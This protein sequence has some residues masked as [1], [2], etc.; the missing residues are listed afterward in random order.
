MDGRRHPSTGLS[1][2]DVESDTVAVECKYRQSTSI[3]A[4]LR[5][6]FRQMRDNKERHPEKTS[7]AV[8]GEHFGRG[9]PIKVYVVIEANIKED[10]FERKLAE[11]IEAKEWVEQQLD[12]LMAGAA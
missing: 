7:I 9:V 11:L 2:V 3:P 1:N 10:L 4:W 8:V 6:M 5:E 12:E